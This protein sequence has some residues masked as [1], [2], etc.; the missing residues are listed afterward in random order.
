MKHP[1][2]DVLPESPK[3]TTDRVCVKRCVLRPNNLL[4]LISCI[5]FR[6]WFVANAF[7]HLLAVTRN[8]RQGT[9]TSLDSED[10][11]NLVWMYLIAG[12]VIAAIS[13]TFAPREV[14]VNVGFVPSLV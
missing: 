10:R 7:Q 11:K 6:R 1:Q 2:R 8:P 4:H 13:E 3:T 12:A 14:E 9:Q 5:L